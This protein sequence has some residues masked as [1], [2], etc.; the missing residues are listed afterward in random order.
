MITAMNFGLVWAPKQKTTK[1]LTAYKNVNSKE[2]CYN[3]FTTTFYGQHW[4]KKA[5]ILNSNNPCVYAYENHVDD[6]FDDDD[7]HR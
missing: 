3:N 2:Y 6:D 1:M 5:P 7:H 4:E